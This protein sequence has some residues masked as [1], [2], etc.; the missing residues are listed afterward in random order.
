MNTTIIVQN[1]LKNQT[2]VLMFKL[3]LTSRLTFLKNKPLEEHFDS[4]VYLISKVYLF[5]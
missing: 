5:I 2:E 1:K 3:K 4:K